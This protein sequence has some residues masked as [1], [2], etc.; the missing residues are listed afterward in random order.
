MK[1]K[2]TQKKTDKRGTWAYHSVDGWY[3]YTSPE[4]YRTHACHI[5]A[6]NSEQLTDTMQLQ[7][8]HITNPTVTTA[9][10][11]MAALADCIK[12]VKGATAIKSRNELKELER[13]VTSNKQHYNEEN[14]VKQSH[15]QKQQ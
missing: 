12:A 1:H 10:K 3:L 2:S 9:D 8:K 7:H 15:T 4:H 14:K 6:T 11:I 5:K 13:L